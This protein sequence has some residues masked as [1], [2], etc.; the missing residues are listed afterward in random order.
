MAVAVNPKLA[1]KLR[2]LEAECLRVAD[3]RLSSSELE[4]F[5]IYDDRLEQLNKSHSQSWFGDHSTTY[6]K[7]FAAP[8][9]GHTFNV[10]WGF[11]S[12]FHGSYNPGWH[13]YSRDEVR[14]F[15]FADIGEDIF[16]S[17]NRLA[18]DIQEQFRSIHD[19][20]LDV[21]EV[22]ASTT[23]S[24]AIERYTATIS[25]DLKP[26]SIVD[27]I[28]G[29]LNSTPNMTRDSE[30][31]SKGR[32]APVHVQY[33]APIQSCDV[34]RRRLRELA[35]TLRNVIE[36]TELAVDASALK[37][38][39]KRVFIG[40]GRSKEWL[41]LKDFIT[42]RLHLEF[43]EFNRVSAAGIGTQERLHEM[44]EKCGFAFLIFTA[45][46]AHEDQSLHARENVIHEAGLFQGKLDFR[47]AII[48]LE[49]GCKEFSNIVGLGQI[50]FSKGDI[51]TCFEEVRR[52][53]EREGLISK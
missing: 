45:E 6:Y 8:P 32:T 39:S 13:C 41:V 38:D 16:E 15:A 35:A 17:V 18:D 42:G 24:R 37:L 33:L 7:D 26:Y 25:A 12:G 2:A 3:L 49:D 52:V 48:L 29:R 10:E 14:A 43:E 21:L 31:I 51:S 27:Y 47:R 36:V 34:N 9:G 30:E 40:H 11:V 4:K 19:Q 53:L 28:N 5:K 44:L 22:L 50:R 46:D 1:A 20:V 23:S